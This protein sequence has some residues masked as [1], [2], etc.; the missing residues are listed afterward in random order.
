MGLNSLSREMDNV[1]RLFMSSN[2][3]EEDAE[4]NLSIV[5]ELPLN[6]VE[7]GVDI[8][9]KISTQKK[10]AYPD[11]QDSQINIKRRLQELISKGY[12]INRIELKKNTDIDKPGRKETREEEIVIFLK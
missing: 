9:E 7:E 10:I 2:D 3:N 4:K 6:G 5:K 8:E 11:N 1:S 12:D